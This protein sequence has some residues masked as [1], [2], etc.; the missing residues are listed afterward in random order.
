MISFHKSGK[1]AS[2]ESDIEEIIKSFRIKR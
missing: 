1:K 2:L